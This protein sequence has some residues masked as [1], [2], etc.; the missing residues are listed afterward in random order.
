MANLKLLNVGVLALQGGFAVH[1]HALRQLNVSTLQVRTPAHLAKCDA[2]IIPGGESTAI[3]RQMNFI[4]IWEPLKEFAKQK[5]I[6]GTCAGLIL[7]SSEIVNSAGTTPFGFLDATVERNS[8]GRQIESFQTDLE[9]KPPE[10]KAFI[11]PAVFIRAPRIRRVGPN[12]KVLATYHDEP[13][14]IQDHIH[15]GSTFHPELTN[16]TRV[17]SYFLS[18]ITQ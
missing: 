5:P 18:L 11:A 10:N 12:V 14:L 1:E 6:F 4:Q 8:Y 15:L 17:H 13:A 7:I 2:L 16:D 9:I 3:F